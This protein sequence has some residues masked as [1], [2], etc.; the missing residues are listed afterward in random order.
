MKVTLFGAPWCSSCK[1]MRD[2]LLNMNVTYDYVDVDTDEGGELATLNR[3][4]S[5]PTML[6][7]I[8]DKREILVGSKNKLFMEDFIKEFVTE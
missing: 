8:D 2:V 3:V 1:G 4:R 5:L 6:F 7:Q